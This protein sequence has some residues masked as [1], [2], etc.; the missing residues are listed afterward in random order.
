MV[1]SIQQNLYPEST[2]FGCG[3]ANPEGL[4][5]SSFVT[6]DGVI[7]TF[8]PK[9]NHSNG[10]GSLN[11]GIIATVLDCHSGA[12]VL[13]ETSA[14]G[15]LTDMWVT[16]GLELRYRLPTFL[17]GPCH[18]LA[19]ITDRSEDSMVVSATLSYE[20]KVRVQAQSRWAKIRKRL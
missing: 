9:A 8:T 13:Q 2:C 14:A 11:G 18:L 1:V 6:E 3:P 10:M 16:S 4:Q 17:D 5:I 15:T 7:G 20:D 12:A 19:R